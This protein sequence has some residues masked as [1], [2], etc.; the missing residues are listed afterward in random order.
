VRT[1]LLSCLAGGL[2]GGGVASLSSGFGLSP[3]VALI[4]FSVTGIAVGYVVSILIDVFSP[5]RAS[6][7]ES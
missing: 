1:R 4:V 6:D 5:S 3:T 7:N 2:L